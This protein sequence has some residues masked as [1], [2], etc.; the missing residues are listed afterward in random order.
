MEQEVILRMS[1]I[2]KAFPGVQALTTINFELRR[3]EV[4]CLLGENG[5]GKSTLIK[6]LSGAHQKDSG[7]ITLN[8]K[9]VEIRN[10]EVSRELGISTIY[11]EMS[12]IPAMSVAE[13]IFL[14]EELVKS[15]FYM[16]DKK[17]MEKQA[18]RIFEENEC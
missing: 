6:I 5:A 15:H 10:A 14:G 4:H 8:G 16:V 3:G 7:T 9:E 1:N 18:H 2:S 13:N 12:L 11:Q 17:E